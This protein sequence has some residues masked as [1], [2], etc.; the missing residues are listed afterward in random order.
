[1]KDDYKEYLRNRIAE[2]R[3]MADSAQ[4]KELKAV[5]ELDI[6]EMEMDLAIAEFK[7]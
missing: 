4:D 5:I 7:S 6:T 2:Y 3:G 1:M